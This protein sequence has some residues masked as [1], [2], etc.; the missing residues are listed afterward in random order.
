V[1][2]DWRLEPF[3]GEPE[4]AT[5][6]CKP[7]DIPEWWPKV[8]SVDW[9][10][11]AMTHALWGAAGPNGRC[12]IYREYAIKQAK[13]STWATEIGKLSQEKLSD[14]VL[15]PSAWDNQGQDKTINILFADYSGL[16][17]RKA[18]NDRLG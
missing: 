10:Y 5:H 18:D 1:F 13:I 14:V 3:P 6:I 12:Y 15:D 8:L 16:T 17:P 7:F 4:N 2:E 11:S 9:G